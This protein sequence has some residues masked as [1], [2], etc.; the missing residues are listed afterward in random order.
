MRAPLHAYRGFTLIELV[1]TLVILAILASV[2]LPRLIEA[3]PFAERGY[4]DVVS[5]S[6]RQARAMAM[7]ST[8]DVQYSINGAGYTAMQRTAAAGH[9]NPAAGFTVLVTSGFAP[10]GVTPAVNRVVVFN[11]SGIP[12]GGATTIN[13]GPHVIT[14]DTNGVVQ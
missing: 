1:A 10:D 9:C 4:A 5:A 3:T 6:L 11:A 7:A 12:A 14:L 8:C 2:S 13:I